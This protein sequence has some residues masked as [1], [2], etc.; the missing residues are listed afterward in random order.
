MTQPVF[1][2]PERVSHEDATVWKRGLGQG[3]E[4]GESEGARVIEVF[5]G[6]RAPVSP[7]VDFATLAI[8]GA[9][10]AT[11]VG[12]AATPLQ[13]LVQA[14]SWIDVG[15]IEVLLYGL[16]VGGVAAAANWWRSREK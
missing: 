2:Q 1:P 3:P 6:P 11:L 16:G 9:V 13:V 8:G 4:A 12:L 7:T 10:V 14:Y 15:R 5:H